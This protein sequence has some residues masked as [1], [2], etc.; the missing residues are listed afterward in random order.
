MSHPVSP[1]SGRGLPRDDH[2]YRYSH[3]GFRTIPL[4]STK[5]KVGVPEIF[6][7]S[8]GTPA[9]ARTSSPSDCRTSFTVSAVRK[10]GHN[11]RDCPACLLLG[12][13]PLV[14]RRAVFAEVAP[15]PEPE[16]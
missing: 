14:K 4:R 3:S 12:D 2:D 6:N 5:S 9:S 15:F 13:E 10:D 16:Y 11:S 7:L 1:A 8:K